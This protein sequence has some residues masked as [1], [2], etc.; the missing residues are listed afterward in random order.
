[1]ADF[2]H[3]P[4]GAPGITGC[5]RVVRTG[6]AWRTSAPTEG[7]Q[8]ETRRGFRRGSVSV[9]ARRLGRA[10]KAPA[11]AQSA[12]RAARVT[13]GVCASQP[14]RALYGL[15]E[16]RSAGRRMSEP[17]DRQIVTTV[18]L[19]LRWHGATSKYAYSVDRRSGSSVGLHQTPHF[20]SSGGGEPK[21]QDVRA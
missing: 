21:A 13:G 14:S 12:L 10:D 11:C 6:S 20:H 2:C 15:R 17:T 8:R 5:R 9:L 18:W 19:A 1:M 7:A 16:V 4:F 3:G